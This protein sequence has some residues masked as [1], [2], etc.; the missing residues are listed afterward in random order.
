MQARRTEAET[1]RAAPSGRR[2]L[3]ADG[4]ASSS[5]NP[6][7]CF[8][9]AWIPAG[10]GKW[11]SPCSDTLVWACSSADERSTRPL[12]SV[13]LR[14]G[15]R[16]RRDVTFGCLPDGASRRSWGRIRAPRFPGVQNQHVLRHRTTPSRTASFRRRLTCSTN[17]T[18]AIR[19]S[20]AR[21]WHPF[22][23]RP[24]LWPASR[25]WSGGPGTWLVRRAG[26]RGSGPATLESAGVPGC[27]PGPASRC[28]WSASMRAKTTL[29]RRRL[30]ARMAIIEGM[31]PARRAS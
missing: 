22:M 26:V 13:L 18:R 6:A 8:A 2:I 30:R 17:S 19:Q 23:S 25:L 29:D 5:S 9:A 11:R 12:G 28:F 4:C 7:C 21:S 27:P 1:F 16:R 20:T 15:I 10:R 3:S 31:P 24:C 14:G